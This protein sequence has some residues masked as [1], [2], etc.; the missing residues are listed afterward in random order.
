MGWEN[1]TGLGLSGSGASTCGVV[2]P[3]ASQHPKA[4]VEGTCI[5]LEHV[6]QHICQQIHVHQPAHAMQLQ[7]ELNPYKVV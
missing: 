4:P 1:E 6:G 7:G 5:A 3:E 2:W